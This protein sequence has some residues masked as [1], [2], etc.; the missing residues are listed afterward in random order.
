MQISE[1]IEI[2]VA[3]IGALFVQRDWKMAVAESCTG[4]GIMQALTSISGSSAWVDS[5]LVTYSNEAKE[6]LLGVPANVLITAGAVSERCAMAMIAGIRPNQANL[7]RLATTG[8][9]GPLGGTPTKPVGTVFIASQSPQQSIQVRRMQFSGTRTEVVQQTIFYALRD[10][11]LASIYE[12]S[13]DV[14]CFYA[15]MLEDEGLQQ[16]CHEHALESGISLLHLEP[17]C[18]LHVTLAYYGKTDVKKRHDLCCLGEQSAE[19]AKSFVLKITH[20]SY[21][22]KNHCVVFDI[23]E[24]TGALIFL[25]KQLGAQNLTPHLTISKR[26]IEYSFQRPKS[27]LS[28]NWK[29][30]S[31]SLMCSFKGVFYHELKKWQLI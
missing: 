30:S 3:A 11:V 10:V 29:V 16:A 24:E 13:S 5:G 23:E 14:Q 1:R 26:N 2:L 22:E 27:P 4:G 9:A 21:W 6:A 25:S 19:Q 12:E 20:L 7:F 18:N 15:L 31:F 17:K 28:L 8:I